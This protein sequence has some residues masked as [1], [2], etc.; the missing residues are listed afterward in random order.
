MPLALG[1]FHA[2]LKAWY[3]RKGDITLKGAD[4]RMVMQ[5]Y[6]GCF[7]VGSK[8]QKQ[9]SSAVQVRIRTIRKII[10]PES[11]KKKWAFRLPDM[12]YIQF[13]HCEN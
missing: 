7:P 10:S 4:K 11:T 13:R 3:E 9:A 6:L 8:T 12:V 1:P 5:V 2:A